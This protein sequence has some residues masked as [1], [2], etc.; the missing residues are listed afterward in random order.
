MPDLS[1]FIPTSDSSEWLRLGLLYLHLLSCALAL[2]LVLNADWR[3]LRGNYTVEGLRQ[4]AHGTTVLLI[5]LW[6]T[7]GLLIHHDT[8]FDLGVMATLSK[9]QLKLVVVVALTL[10]GVLLHYVSFPLMILQR[11]L[12]GLEAVVLATSGIISSSHWLLAAFIGIARPLGQW[13]RDTLLSIYVCALCA[14][15]VLGVLSAPVLRHLLARRLSGISDTLQERHRN[16][17]RVDAGSDEFHPR[18]PIRAE[19][20]IRGAVVRVSDEHSVFRLRSR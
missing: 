7:G 16:N 13:P 20:M 12:T 2:A 19:Q 4:T 5:L 15:I 8:G 17:A 14:M 3:I 9:L 18:A 1:M 6:I 11:R 10:N